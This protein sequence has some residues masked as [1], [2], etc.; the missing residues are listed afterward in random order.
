MEGYTV[1][2][3][4]P[5]DDTLCKCSDCGE[6]SQ[7]EDL[8]DIEEATLTPG[9]D[10]PAGRCPHCQSL[11]Y[12]VTRKTTMRDASGAMLSAL[13]AIRARINGVFDDP[14]LVAKGALAFTTEDVLRFANEAIAAAEGRAP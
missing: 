9:D 14:D 13:K 8:E 11:A 3:D 2:I 12:V 10:S 6:V 5:E 4:E 7:F 1:T